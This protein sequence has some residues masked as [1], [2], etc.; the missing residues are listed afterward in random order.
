M[1]HWDSNGHVTVSYWWSM[2]G[3]GHDLNIFGA[4]Y[5]DNGWR[6]GLGANGAPIANDYW[7]LN[8]HVTSPSVFEIFGVKHIGVT[9]LTFQGHVTI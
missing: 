2:K 8:G 1:T 9:T 4:H 5:L 7:E 6:Y 3:Q